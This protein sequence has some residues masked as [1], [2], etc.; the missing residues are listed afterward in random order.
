MIEIGGVSGMRWVDCRGNHDTFG[1][2]DFGRRGDYY[3]VRYGMMRGRGNVFVEMFEGRVRVVGLQL[4]QMPGPHRPVNFFGVVKK[5]VG[6][7]LRRVLM[8]GCLW[9]GVTVL[10]GHF[11]SSTLVFEERGLSLARLNGVCDEVR[12][13]KGLERRGAFVGYLSGHLHSAGDDEGFGTKVV[14]E[15]RYVEMQMADLRYSKAYRILVVDYG[16]LFWKSLRLE[17][18]FP[19]ALVT[20]PAPGSAAVTSTHIRVFVYRAKEERWDDSDQKRFIEVVIDGSSFGT[21]ESEK[22]QPLHVLKWDPSLYMS[23][24]HVLQVYVDDS[25]QPIETIR[26][27]LDKARSTIPYAP[28]KRYHVWWLLSDFPSM[29]VALSKNLTILILTFLILPKTSLPC[30]RPF[31]A[32]RQFRR[33]SWILL[34]SFGITLLVAPL[35]ISTRFYHPNRAGFASLLAFGPSVRASDT[36]LIVVI[37]HLTFIYLPLLYLTL[38]SVATR[39][40][41]DFEQKVRKGLR[42][43]AWLA[44]CYRIYAHMVRMLFAYGWF[45]GLISPSAFPTVLLVCIVAF[46][47]S[48]PLENVPAFKEDE[49]P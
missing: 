18:S 4:A 31:T 36:S 20:N 27:K 26:F 30:L 23:G 1:V 29:A 41:S 39:Q 46:V 49:R 19:V 44:I 5:E 12:L 16:V 32:L 42:W 15:G 28:N 2:E 48:E 10:F 3:G 8:E 35:I 17:D 25:H 33:P 38:D 40:R 14:M 45:A 9:D 7:E 22:D 43:L 37:P 34:I 11:P 47:N 6:W 24:E 21:V 13:E